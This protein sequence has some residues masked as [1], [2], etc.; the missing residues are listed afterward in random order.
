MASLDELY[1]SF[2]PILQDALITVK[3]DY[4]ITVASSRNEISSMVRN[5]QAHVLSRIG[6]TAQ[7]MKDYQNDVFLEIQNRWTGNINQSECFANAERELEVSAATAG[8]FIMYA[9]RQLSSL[10]DVLAGR[11]IF[12]TVD[13]IDLLLSLL[14][15]EM[16]HLF[17]FFS[18]VTEIHEIILIYQ[19]GI[20]MTFN[21]FDL[22][23]D[24]ILLN[25]LTFESSTNQLNRVVFFEMT[26]G[27]EE[28][29]LAGATIISTF[30]ECL[31]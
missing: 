22:F 5:N 10:N 1:L 13:E 2:I 21:L 6:F 3:E 15:F 28:F 16:F 31:E 25:M 27:L 12:A 18:G 4:R 17:S 29:K 9:A 8:E 24:E 23:V 7:E 30:N 26:R 14:E 11:V 20:Q 19:T